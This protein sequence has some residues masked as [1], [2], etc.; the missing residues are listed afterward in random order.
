MDIA[1]HADTRQYI[2]KHQLL[3]VNPRRGHYRCDGKVPAELKRDNSVFVAF[4]R[5]DKP[6]IVIATIV[7]NGG[8]CSGPAAQIPRAVPD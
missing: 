2:K 1:R 5:L 4:S 7:E 8:W 3:Y 6:K